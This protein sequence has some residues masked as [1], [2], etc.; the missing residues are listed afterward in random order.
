MSQTLQDESIS[1]PESVS[2]STLVADARLLVPLFDKLPSLL[3][4]TRSSPTFED[5]RHLFN[6]NITAQ[7]LAIIRPKS[8]EEVSSVVSFC[9]SQKPKVPLAIRSGGHDMAGRCL[10]EDGVVIDIRALNRIELADDKT[11]A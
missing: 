9:S 5:V 7:P 8:E 2:R 10:V 6:Y 11:S 3:I 4:Y 1:N